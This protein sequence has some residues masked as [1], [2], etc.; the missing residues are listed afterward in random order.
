VFVSL[1]FAAKVSKVGRGGHSPLPHWLIHLGALGLFAVSF[2]DSSVVPL[3][4]PG[5]TDLLLLFLTA[6]KGNPWLLGAAA[7]AGSILGGYLT[8]GTGKKGGEAALHKYISERRLKTISKWVERHSILAVFLPAMLPPPVPLTPFLLSAGAL[9]VS[10]NKFLV[11]FSAARSARYGLIA[12]LGVTYGRGV[13]R[14]WSR[15]VA[16]WSTPIIWVLVVLTVGGVAYGYWKWRRLQRRDE[17][18]APSSDGLVGA[19]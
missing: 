12:W 18:A 17:V 1:I 19:G 4:L 6:H 14:V 5:S 2:V 10:R 15:Y 11:A 8:W 9:G 3:P 7:I 16:G 13:V